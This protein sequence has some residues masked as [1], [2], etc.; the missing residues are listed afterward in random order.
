MK[1]KDFTSEHLDKEVTVRGVIRIKMN[2][3]TSGQDQSLS[4]CVSDGTG[5]VY[6]TLYRNKQTA[7]II[8]GLNGV[9]DGDYVEVRGILKSVR[10][11]EKTYN[12]F[13]QVT[14]A[15]YVVSSAVATYRLEEVRSYLNKA[16]RSITDADLK[17]FVKK[18]LSS[19]D[20]YWKAP[21][22]TVNQYSF[23]SGLAC[24][25]YDMLKAVD[26]L[27]D[28]LYLGNVD[29][30][31]AAIFAHRLGKINTIENNDGKIEKTLEGRLNSDYLYTISFCS[32]VLRSMNMPSDKEAHLMHVI[33]TSKGKKEFGALSEPIAIEARMLHII[34]RMILESYEGKETM[35]QAKKSGEVFADSTSGLYYIA[36]EQIVDEQE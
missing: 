33:S 32:N 5:N 11:S 1:I 18:V 7:K 23:K 36:P 34:E 16:Y 19:T 29:I 30:L 28:Q 9:V 8:Q 21:Y 13:G 10:D 17:Q 25:T 6:A 24:Y 3:A 12:R 35:L 15:S 27:K 2:E 20:G 4:I 14:Y 31:K 26:A 22:A